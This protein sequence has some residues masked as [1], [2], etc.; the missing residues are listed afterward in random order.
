MSQRWS[1]LMECCFAAFLYL[2]QKKDNISE[3]WHR[4]EVQQWG[5]VLSN[6][7]CWIW[8]RRDA[9]PR[10]HGAGRS[11]VIIS[12][13]FKLNSHSSLCLMSFCMD[14]TQISTSFTE[15]TRIVNEAG[16]RMQQLLVHVGCFSERRRRRWEDTG[17]RL[18]LHYSIAP[19]RTGQMIWPDVFSWKSTNIN[20]EC[21]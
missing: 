9:L 4:E 12:S 13:P 8:T 16:G 15:Q 5:S 6:S 1:Q 7:I 3:W 2:M 17:W 11:T 18:A 10:T 19:V 14:S 21:V 20:S